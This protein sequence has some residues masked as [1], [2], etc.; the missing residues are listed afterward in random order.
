MHSLHVNHSGSGYLNIRKRK[1]P[2]YNSLHIQC[3]A[4]LQLCHDLRSRDAYYPF[5]AALSEAY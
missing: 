4:P 1:I 5:L 2:A 3:N